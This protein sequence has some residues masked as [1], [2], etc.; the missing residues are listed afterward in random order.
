MRTKTR[1]T[2]LHAPLAKRSPRLERQARSPH[3]PREHW[4][5]PDR[6]QPRQSP[7]RR[8]ARARPAVTGSAAP[9]VIRRPCLARRTPPRPDRTTTGG[10]SRRRPS[11]KQV[12]PGG[13][14]SR[15][16]SRFGRDRSFGVVRPIR[17]RSLLANRPEDG[18]ARAVCFVPVPPHDSAV[19]RVRRRQ[20]PTS[21]HVLRHPRSTGDQAVDDLR[22]GPADGAQPQELLAPRPEP[23]LRGAEAAR[24]RRARQ[25]DPGPRRTAAA[26]HLLHHR[27]GTPR[28]GNGGWP[29]P[30]AARRS[31]SKPCSRCSSPNT[32][33]KQDVL[34]NI[35]A[36]REWAEQQN[37]ENIAFARLYRDTGGPFPDRLAVHHTD[38]QV[39]HRLRRHGRPLGRVGDTHRRRLAR[40]PRPASNPTGKHFTISRRP[41]RAHSPLRGGG[42][43]T[44]ANLLP[45]DGG[46]DG[47]HRLVDDL[48][49]GCSA[50]P[51]TRLRCILGS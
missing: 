21:H 24:G 10:Q 14:C 44:R 36:I 35:A 50:D 23:H 22:A 16:H 45:V 41:H 39:P 42:A 3:R 31:S 4:R 11:F 19:N 46:H 13:A 43:S 32:A 49:R 15:E 47:P 40:R 7:A 27:Q 34:A 29:N 6:E 8:C 12:T 20:R 9:R 30:G 51:T 5:S 48:A 28:A 18:P 33:R 17:P 1:K 2:G 25:G 37:A 38:R 26:D